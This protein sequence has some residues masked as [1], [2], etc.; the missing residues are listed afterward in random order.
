[1]KPQA[2]DEC[3]TVTDE[4]VKFLCDWLCSDCAVEL[5]NAIFDIEHEE[6]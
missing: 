4:L 1:M 6:E 3:G 5:N 2:C